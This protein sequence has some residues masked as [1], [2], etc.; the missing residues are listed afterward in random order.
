MPKYDGASSKTNGYESS[1]IAKV[2]VRKTGRS[3]KEIIKEILPNPTMM[4]PGKEYAQIKELESEEKR[5]K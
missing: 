4:M 2:P 1:S 3:Y 5:R